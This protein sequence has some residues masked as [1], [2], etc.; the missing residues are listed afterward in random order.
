MALVGLGMSIFRT[1]TPFRVLFKSW[2]WVEAA[3]C[4]AGMMA[5]GCSGNVAP[6]CV[7]DKGN[8]PTVRQE[9]FRVFHSTSPMQKKKKNVC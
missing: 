2:C 4:V 8:A 1:V 6:A 3:Y 9:L 5:S 7:A